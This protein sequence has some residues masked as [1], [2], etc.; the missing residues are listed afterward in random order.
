MSSSL[1]ESIQLNRAALFDWLVIGISFALGFFFPTLSK[2]IWSQS[3]YVWIL[4]ALLSYTLGAALKDFPLSYRLS[5]LPRIVEPVP[6]IIFLL[7]GHWFIIVSMVILAEP[8]FRPLFGLP[9]M[10]KDSAM[11]WQIALLST[12]WAFV[13]TWLVYRSKS[14][15]KFKRKYSEE[16]IFRFELIADLFLIAGVSF[17]TFLFWEKGVMEML[18]HASTKSFGDIWFLFLFLSFLFLFFY[19]PLRYLFFMEDR[20]ASGNRKRL[21]LIFAFVLGRALVDMFSSSSSHW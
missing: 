4:V 16:F 1:R 8:L 21:L 20:K 14:N 7:A 2:F 18:A 11:S 19:L 12:V 15:R 10:A 5:H 17:F 6:Y 3:F 9:S 13:L